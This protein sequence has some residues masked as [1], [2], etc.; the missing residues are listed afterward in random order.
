MQFQAFVDA[1]D[2]YQ[3]STWWQ[4]LP[5]SNYWVGRQEF[6]YANHPRENVSWYDAIAFC[7]W[8]STE[9]Q[10]VITLPTEQQWEKAARGTDGRAWPWGSQYLVGYAN[11]DERDEHNPVGPTYLRS[12]TAV[13]L[14]PWGES[15]YGVMDMC[16]NVWEWCLNDASNMN[17]TAMGEPAAPKQLRGGSW[18]NNIDVAPTYHRYTD[19]VSRPI[20]PTYR[21]WR[22]GFRVVA[23][24]ST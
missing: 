9:L 2:G 5:I 10:R 18:N 20:L 1:P 21:N 24:D 3:N 16:G 22:V 4:G 19:L 12:T 15:P 13:G 8:L 6:N 11:V 14:Y 17:G 23:L 7:R